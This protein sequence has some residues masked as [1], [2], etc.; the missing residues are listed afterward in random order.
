MREDLM[1]TASDGHSRFFKQIIYYSNIT[2][3]S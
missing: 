2:P 3:G 1:L